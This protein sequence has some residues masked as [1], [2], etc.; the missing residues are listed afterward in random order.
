MLRDGGIEASVGDYEIV[1]FLGAGTFSRVYEGRHRRRPEATVAI[2]LIA[3]SRLAETAFE[4]ECAVHSVLLAHPHIVR[5]VDAFDTEDALVLVTEHC[6]GGDLFSFVHRRGRLEEPLVCH[7]MQQVLGALLQLH[8]THRVVHRDVKLENILLDDPE[9]PRVAKL[10]D[11]GLA[12]EY[13]GPLRT[14]CGSEDYAAP[15]LIAGLPYDPERTDVWSLGVAM[16]TCLYGRLPFSKHHGIR[17]NSTNPLSLYSQ[18]LAGDVV[19][20]DDVVRV[21]GDCRELLGSMLSRDPS[22][23]PSFLSLANHAWFKRGVMR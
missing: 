13:T 2:K 14:R 11:F 8:W 6:R 20:W 23:R 15:E 19:F 12:R 7:L 9:Q 10:A 4:T 17:T 1:R 18:I 22:R 16:Y 21:S 5:L 3:R